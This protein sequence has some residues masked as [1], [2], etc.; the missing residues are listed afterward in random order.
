MSFAT[1]FSFR[2]KSLKLTEPTTNLKGQ[3]LGNVSTNVAKGEKCV[4]RPLSLLWNNYVKTNGK[5]TILMKLTVDNSGLK[6]YTTNQGLTH[7]WCHRISYFRVAKD[8]PKL[9]VWIYRHVGKKLK[10]E[11]RCHAILLSSEKKAAGLVDLLTEK[12]A[13][14]LQEYRREKML[15]HRRRLLHEKAA[16]HLSQHGESPVQARTKLL[17]TSKNYK[18]PS[19][20]SLSSPTLTAISEEVDCSSSEDSDY[21]NGSPYSTL[22]R[23]TFKNKF[24][25]SNSEQLTPDVN[26]NQLPDDDLAEYADTANG[27]ATLPRKSRTNSNRRLQKRLLV[28]RLES[29]VIQSNESAIDDRLSDSPG[30]SYP[31][32]DADEDDE[33]SGAGSQS[34]SGAEASPVTSKQLLVSQMSEN[35]YTGLDEDESLNDSDEELLQDLSLVDENQH[36]SIAHFRSF[37]D[38]FYSLDR[39][40]LSSE[41]S[42]ISLEKQKILFQTKNQLSAESGVGSSE[43]LNKDEN[44]TKDEYSIN[45]EQDLLSKGQLQTGTRDDEKAEDAN[46][47]EPLFAKITS[48]SDPSVNSSS[49]FHIEKSNKN[50]VEGDEVKTP[51]IDKDFESDCSDASI[52]IIRF[53]THL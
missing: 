25:R 29:L 31:E 4:D 40:S 24:R 19:E 49:I 43:T 6:V 41:G 12:V 16:A 27:F 52:E 11:L 17:A 33:D 22:G 5:Q 13:A 42:E 53:I 9:F 21:N 7:Y 28:D 48:P 38:G 10:V 51:Y 8:N 20:Y 2:K 26:M 50:N 36:D 32:S 14:S 35:S 37:S 39:S 47:E 3:Y 44:Q 18:P 15:K 34:L 45:N 46:R 30:D 1:L 23:W